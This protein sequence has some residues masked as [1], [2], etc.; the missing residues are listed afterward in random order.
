MYPGAGGSYLI[1]ILEVF[2]HNIRR[3][4]LDVGYQE[5]IAVSAFDP[6]DVGRHLP[7]FHHPP[8]KH[9]H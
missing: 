7:V 8:P 9:Q 2:G 6:P 3:K 5:S 4:G 1:H